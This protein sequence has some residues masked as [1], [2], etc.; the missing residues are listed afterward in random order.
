LKTSYPN[1]FNPLVTIDYSVKN[2]DKITLSIVDLNGNIIQTLI[3]DKMAPSDYSIVWDA[4]TF[5]SGVYFIQYKSAD[6]IE[7]Q[8]ITLIK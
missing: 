3:S 8:K 7:N 2:F 4:S 6:I 5:P 1:P